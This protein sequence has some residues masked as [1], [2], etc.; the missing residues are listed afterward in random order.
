MKKN[1][2]YGIL[3]ILL[4]GVAIYFFQTNSKSTIR[5]KDSNFAIEDTSKISAIRIN[6]VGQEVYLERTTNKWMI[7]GG[8]PA[9]PSAIDAFF[10]IMMHLEVH[11]PVSKSMQKKI[12]EYLSTKGFELTIYSGSKI[13]KNVQIYED[14]VNNATY[15]MLEGARQPFAMQLPGYSSSIGKLFIADKSYWRDNTVFASNV[16]DILMVSVDYTLEPSM[17][18]AIE[19]TGNDFILKSLYDGD[20]VKEADRNKILNYL[21]EFNHVVFDKFLLENI[22]KPEKEEFVKEDPYLIITLKDV[23]NHVFTLKGFPIPVEGE[24]DE[25]GNPIKFDLDRM[26]GLLNE[27]DLVTVSYFEISGILKKLNDFFKE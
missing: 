24:F 21:Y 6:K 5:K 25:L 19:N 10:N 15:M 13:I 16:S 3:V 22:T 17:S 8:I 20:V 2:I 26:Y 1:L 12:I 11:A 23:Y 14:T 7:D 27:K 4:I 9:R 18:Y